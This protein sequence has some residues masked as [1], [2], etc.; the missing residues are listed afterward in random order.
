MT[1]SYFKDFLKYL[2]ITEEHFWQIIDRYRRPNVWKKVNGEWKLRH[3][4]AKDGT[5]D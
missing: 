3:T 1:S 4:V 2:D 5:D